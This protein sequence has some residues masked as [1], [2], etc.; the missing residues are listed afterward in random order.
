M[1]FD[2][3]LCVIET[4]MSTILIILIIKHTQDCLFQYRSNAINKGPV[5]K[6]GKEI[7]EKSKCKHYH[8][9]NLDCLSIL[10]SNYSESP[11]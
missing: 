9:K 7:I 6:I 5:K 2:L 11:N 10:L 1:N 3:H 4:R 8:F